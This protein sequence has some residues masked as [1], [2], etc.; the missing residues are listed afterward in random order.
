MEEYIMAREALMKASDNKL[1]IEF[2]SMINVDGYK[3]IIE[4]K[5][6]IIDRINMCLK[7]TKIGGCDRYNQN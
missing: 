7:H 1:R 3:Y 2:T 5:E 4:N 6:Q